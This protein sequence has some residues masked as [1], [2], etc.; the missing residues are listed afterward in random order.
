[1]RQADHPLPLGTTVS[2]HEVVPGS[3]RALRPKHLATMMTFRVDP[4]LVTKMREI[5][6]AQGLSTSEALRAAMEQW[7]NRNQNIEDHGKWLS[8]QN[9]GDPE[10]P[11]EAGSRTGDWEQA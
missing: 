8:W 10:N 7:V 1:M 6:T 11:Y 9:V 3:G 4:E 5:A 2:G